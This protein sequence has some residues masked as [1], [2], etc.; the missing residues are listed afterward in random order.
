MPEYD[1]P[2]YRVDGPAG[3]PPMSAGVA[4]AVATRG[5]RG[6]AWL[7]QPAIFLQSTPD[8]PNGGLVVAAFAIAAIIAS[9]VIGVVILDRRG[10]D[11]EVDAKALKVGVHKRSNDDARTLRY[12]AAMS[13][14]SDLEQ[15]LAALPGADEA[16]LGRWFTYLCEH[17]AWVLATGTHRHYRVALWLDDEGDPVNL[18]RLALHGFDRNDPRMAELERETSVAGW[19]VKNGKP[20]YVRDTQADLIYRPRRS[21]PPYRSMYAAPLG[22]PDPWA[23]LTADVDVVD[24]FAPDQ[25]DLLERFGKLATTGAAIAARGATPAGD[26]PSGQ[27][28]GR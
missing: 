23:A 5:G 22:N 12:Q 19:C 14:L 8:L 1:L 20:H 18:K 16:A 13:R 26:D 15:A 6:L 10:L 3:W 11:F 2:S 28:L 7:P 17:L 27:G 9:F 4:T 25:I 21:E 24:G